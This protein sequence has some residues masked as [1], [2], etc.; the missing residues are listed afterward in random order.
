MALI[1]AG[2]A[3]DIAAKY[4]GVELDAIMDD[5]AKQIDKAASNGEFRIATKCDFSRW[6][7][8]ARLVLDQLR[9]AGYAFEISSGSGNDPV[10]ILI[11]W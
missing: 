8:I 2:G 3:R 6:S 11:E 7:P 4:Y 10:S 5:I 9:E 1:T